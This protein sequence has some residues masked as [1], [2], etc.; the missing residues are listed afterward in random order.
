[1]GLVQE[2]Q[3]TGQF[4]HFTYFLVKSSVYPLYIL[5]SLLKEYQI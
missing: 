3:F 4:V 5:L 2:V 1:M